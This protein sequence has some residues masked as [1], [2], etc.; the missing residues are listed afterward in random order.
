MSI[1]NSPITIIYGEQ[2]QDNVD[3]VLKKCMPQCSSI[4]IPG[5]W[6]HV[7]QSTDFPDYVGFWSTKEDLLQNPTIVFPENRDKAK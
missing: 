5:I 2:K 4:L 3:L 1:L 7:H 6:Q